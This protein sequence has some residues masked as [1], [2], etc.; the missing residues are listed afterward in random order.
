MAIRPVRSLCLAFAVSLLGLAPRAQAADLDFI[1]SLFQGPLADGLNG[2]EEVVISDDGLFAYVASEDQVG[3]MGETGA[4][5]IFDLDEVA[6]TIAPN[7]VVVADGAR[8]LALSPGPNN[9]HLYVAANTTNQI[10]WFTRDAGTGQLSNPG[11]ITATGSNGLMEAWSVAVSADG[12]HVYVAGRADHSLAV[13]DRMGDGSLSFV[14]VFTNAGNGMETPVEVRL[15]PDDAQVLVGSASVADDGNLGVA[16]DRAMGDPLVTPPVTIPAVLPGRG[17]SKAIAVSPDGTSVYFGSQTATSTNPSISVLDRDPMTNALTNNDII[18]DP[19]LATV[20]SLAVNPTGTALLA[21][22]DSADRIN[23][24]VRGSDGS[25]TFA[26]AELD[27]PAIPLEGVTSVAITQSGDYTISVAKAGD[28]GMALF[29]P[30]PAAGALGLALL[31]AL[32]ILA[33]RSAEGE[34]PS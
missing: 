22:A 17:V 27:A 4:I 30:E 29:A 28:D 3:P 5:G 24:Y 21:A 19:D 9:E 11:S 18:D 32:G 13:F 6:E 20:V 15:T 33:R 34:T 31:A 10:L 7:D 23:A 14:E 8:A 12:L 2:A 1:M 26:D 25:L 16:F